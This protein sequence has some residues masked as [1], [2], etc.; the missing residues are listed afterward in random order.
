MLCFRWWWAVG[1]PCGRSGTQALSK[2]SRSVPV[3]TL[4]PH[5]HYV[6][7]CSVMVNRIPLASFLYSMQNIKLSQQGVRDRHCWKKGHLWFL[8]VAWWIISVG[9]RTSSRVPPQMCTQNE[10]SLATLQPQIGLAITFLGPTS[11]RNWLLKASR[12]WRCHNSLCR[13]VPQAPPPLHASATRLPVANH[14][15]LPA[16]W[17]TASCSSSD[18][19]QLW[20]EQTSKILSCLV[21]WTLLLNEVW[22]QP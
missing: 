6:N 21:G 8:V 3:I 11:H 15:C 19:D 5:S 4:L 17:R 2:L 1:G 18:I 7:T 14:L 20:L 13:P 16:L 10:R 12:L 9:M 22:P